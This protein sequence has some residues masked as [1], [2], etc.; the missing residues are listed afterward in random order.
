LK[1]WLKT[2]IS[3]QFAFLIVWGCKCIQL[4]KALHVEE[5]KIDM[6]K[7]NIIQLEGTTTL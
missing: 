5:K 4:E 7:S 1:T 2:I 6:I 3:V